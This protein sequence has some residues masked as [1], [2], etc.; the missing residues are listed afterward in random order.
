M[1]FEVSQVSYEYDMN[2]GQQSFYQSPITH[3]YHG[4]TADALR[5]PRR[6]RALHFGFATAVILTVCDEQP[7]VI[8]HVL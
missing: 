5:K 1:Y 7:N 6:A 4:R 8:T 2:T 3:Q